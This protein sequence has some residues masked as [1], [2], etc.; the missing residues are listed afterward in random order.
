MGSS[1]ENSRV[2]PDA[3]SVG[4]DAHAGRLLRR[5]GGGGRGARGLRRARHGHRR[6]DPPAGG[7]LRLVGL[8]PTYGRVSRYGVIAFASS[9]DQVG[10]IARTVAR[11]AR[12]CCRSSPG[13]TRG[14]HLGPAC[15]CRTT[16]RRSEAG[17]NGTEARP[18]ARVLRRRA[19][20]RRWRRRCARRRRRYERLGA[21]VVEVSLP[22][23]KYALAT[24]YMVAPA[25]ASSNLARYDGVRY[26]LR[27]D[28]GQGPRAS[29]TT[30]HAR[31]GLRRRG[32]AAH[33]ARHLRALRRLLRRLLPEGAEGAHADPRRTSRRPSSRWTRSSAP[34][35]PTPAFQ[36]GEK[37]DDPLAMYLTD[38]FTIPCNLA[39]LPGHV[40][41]PAAS[42]SAG[43]PIGLQLIGQAV[44]RGARSCASA[45]AFEREHDF[46]PARARAL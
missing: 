34:T 9:L 16:A 24:Y 38:I 22:H 32:E 36:L 11:R 28:G 26:G 21:E 35:S 13:T 44:R 18:A 30:Q 17:V 45:R 7:A 6:L 23:T 20:T 25:E 40:A 3:Q 10:P 5:L 43:L 31:A 15:R 14:L 29:C 27:A 4:P 33:H 2:R 19:W 1:T 46:A 8:K 39:G 42:P 41:C 12:R 37:V